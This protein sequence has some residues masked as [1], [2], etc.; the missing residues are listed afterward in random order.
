[1]EH[2]KEPWV[3]INPKDGNGEGIAYM[4]GLYMVPPTS[5]NLKRIVT[6]VNALV[7][8]DPGCVERMEILLKKILK[9]C[10]EIPNPYSLEWDAKKLGDEIESALK[11]ESEARG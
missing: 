3:Y 5:E 8:R 2:T 6:C 7:G 4:D 1:M 9:A 10:R 11:S